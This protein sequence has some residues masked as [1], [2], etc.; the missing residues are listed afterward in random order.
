M[1]KEFEEYIKEKGLC[2]KYHLVNYMNEDE[3]DWEWGVRDNFY[4]DSFD[5]KDIWE[6]QQRKIDELK[7]S[8]EADLLLREPSYEHVKRLTK[9]VERFKQAIWLYLP[10]QKPDQKLSQA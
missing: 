9:D 4:I 8:H 6:H 7:L 2:K 3:V 10:L 1:S 5:L